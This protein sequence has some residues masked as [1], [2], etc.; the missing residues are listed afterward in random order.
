MTKDLTVESSIIKYIKSIVVCSDIK[1]VVRSQI[2]TVDG[3][4]CSILM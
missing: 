4:L 3:I 1:L 2:Y